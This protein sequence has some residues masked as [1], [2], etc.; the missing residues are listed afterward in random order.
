VNFNFS[1]LISFIVYNVLTTQRRLRLLR[2]KKADVMNWMVSWWIW[3][4]AL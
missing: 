4:N 1:I 3:R 2:G